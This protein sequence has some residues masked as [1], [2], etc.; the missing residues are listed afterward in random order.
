MNSRSTDQ[1]ILKLTELEHEGGKSRFTMEL[2][3]GSPLVSEWIPK[4]KLKGVAIT[5]CDRVR[6]QLAVAEADKKAEQQRKIDQK[7]RGR[8]A[9][10]TADVPDT[11]PRTAPGPD[12]DTDAEV[13]VMR[14]WRV[15]SR[16]LGEAKARLEKAQ[17][18]YDKWHKL[19]QALE[20]KDDEEE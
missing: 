5:W 7:R 8:S 20:L 3:N 18:N 14:N 6:D 2:P 13:W 17:L 19:Y 15:A 12:E 9:V 11:M 16:E 10:P 4:D 1:D